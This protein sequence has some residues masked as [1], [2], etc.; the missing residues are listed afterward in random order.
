MGLSV[1][2]EALFYLIMKVGTTM[3][4]QIYRSTLALAL[5]FIN[6]CGGGSSSTDG[7]GSGITVSVP[8]APSGVIASAGNAA[9]SVSFSAPSS[10][11]GATISS[12]TASCVSGASAPF[13]TSGGASPL[14]VSGLTNGLAYTCTV[15]ATNSAGNS[16]ASASATVTPS[17]PTSGTSVSY[18]TPAPFVNAVQT[19]YA[20]GSLTPTSALSNRGRYLLSDTSTGGT[21]ANFLTIVD[22]YSATA[23]YGASAEKISSSN[24]TYQSFLAKL[25]QLVVQS[26][27]FYRLDSHLHPNNSID[28]RSADTY[29]L[30]FRNNFGK[31]STK[32][33][34]VTFSYDS[35]TK[36]LQ[37]KKRYLY[38]LAI[39]SSTGT[40]SYTLDSAFAAS[41]YYVKLSGTTFSLV[42][43][44]ANASPL[45][46]FNSPLDLGIPSFMNPKGIGF[47]PNAAAPFKIK[48]SATAVLT[49]F[50]NNLTT[51]YKSQVSV[52]GPDATT[53]TAAD[54][55]LASIKSTLEANSETLRYAPAVYTAFRD[56]ALA[57][58]LVSDGIADGTPGQYMVP[59]VY[60]TNEKDTTTGS[61]HPF[62]VIVHHGN[63]SSPNGL[64]DIPRPPGD[65]TQPYG[66]GKVT[67]YANMEGYV[68]AIP[69]KS[70]GQVSAVT[71]NSFT[72]NLWIDV[73]GMVSLPGSG[74]YSMPKNVYTW[75]DKADN[76]VLIDG[77][78][79]FPVFNN[80]LMPSHLAGE[81]SA[82]G[83]H[84]G[85][86]GGGPHCH[87]DGYRPGFPL[88]LYNDADYVGKVH[89]PLVGFGYDGIA[90]FGMYRSGSD[91]AMLGYAIALDG[92]GA[93]EHDGIGY[94]YHAHTVDNYQPEN[95]TDTTYKSTLH[96]LMKG[97]YVGKTASIPFFRESASFTK[98]KYLGGTVAP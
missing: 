47:V 21:D 52:A 35:S 82:S 50:A 2:R 75:A 18:S 98:N 43:D 8:G 87:A 38:D 23:G 81:L 34:Y 95:T 91:T 80:V 28:A 58:K 64:I 88:G 79:M 13:S 65:G 59:Y 73:N 31:V 6:A 26:D 45:Y 41:D 92:F 4:R 24:A 68:T 10:N 40:A 27:G 46:F 42:A 67:R 78:V 29:Q 76:G 71:Q 39:A 89:P 17:A 96:V 63:Q 56:G 54:A 69:L 44:A 74:S 36:K 33:G 53:K 97:A 16:A 3:R 15:L 86:G 11:G 32:Y 90:L 20:P 77:S 7:S 5:L 85:Q 61:Y 30:K 37:A 83:C 9:T 72:S 19:N 25:V 49:N 22:P 94:H 60:F 48:D 1:S 51:S 14:T 84:V 62:M 66:D 93:H 70:Y 12:Y 57:A 55:M